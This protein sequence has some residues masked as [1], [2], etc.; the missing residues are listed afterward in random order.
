[1]DLRYYFGTAERSAIDRFLWTDKCQVAEPWDLFLLWTGGP[2]MRGA[3][4]WAVG[5]TLR[6]KYFSLSINS[7][8]LPTME[9]NWPYFIYGTQISCLVE[10]GLYSQFEV[11]YSFMEAESGHSGRLAL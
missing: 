9:L 6:C 11:H 8:R 5:Y 4:A 1:M 10:H 2:C 7:W 3:K